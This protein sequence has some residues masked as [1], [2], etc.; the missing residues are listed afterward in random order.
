MHDA[1]EE[2][3]SGQSIGALIVA[4]VVNRVAAWPRLVLGLYLV[5]LIASVIAATGLR[6]DTDSSKMLSPTLD[7]QA[8]ALAL[9]DA[10]PDQKTAI[11]V[12]I[13]A[14]DPD[15]A[16]AVTAELASALEG[17]AGIREI[18]A[19]SIN[20]F[21]LTHGLLYL[22]TDE[23]DS[24]LSRISGSA[25]LI[26]GLRADQT[27][28]GFVST[29]DQALTL[30]EGAGETADLAPVFDEAAA[31]FDAAASGE[32]RAFGWSGIFSGTTGPVLRTITVQPEL[33]Y[34]ALNPAKPALAS[35]RET[36]AEIVMPEGVSVGVTGD[37]ALR[38]EE[39]RS[40]TAK[41]GWSLGLSLIFVIVVLWFAL[42]TFKRMLLGLGALFATLVLTTGFAAVGVGS[43]NL[44]SIAFIVLM[45]GLGIDFAIHFM[46]HLDEKA[47]TTGNALAATA[48]SI[49]PAL[50][51]TAASTSVAFFAFA[52]TDFVGM[53]QLGLIGGVGVLIAFLVSITLI[54]A[55]VSLFPT[56]AF[57]SP[58]GRI[59]SGLAAG[60]VFRLFMVAFGFGAAVLALDSR[61]DADPMGLRDPL[62]P[63]VEA[64]NW[65]AGDPD[66]SPL[67]ASAVVAA[68]DEAE[69]LR[70]LGSDLEG[71]ASATW[72]GSLLPAEQDEKLELVDLAWPSL[73]HA[74][75]GAPDTL[76]TDTVSK[77]EELPARL[78]DVPEAAALK[79][80]LSA[81]LERESAT[82]N[83]AL[84][85][86]LFTHFPLLTGR[87]EAMLEIDVVEEESLPDPLARQFSSGGFYR[88][89]FL[90]AADI[91][92][93]EERASFV[94]ALS[95][96]IPGLTG[97]PAQIEGARVAVSRAMLEAVAIALLGA[98]LLSLVTLRS[99]T[100]TLAILVPVGLAGAVCMAAGVLLDIPFNYANVIVLP[101]MIGIGVDSGIHLAIRSRQTAPV[102][103]T[104]TPMA[105]FYSAMTTIAA[106]GTLGLSDHR[107]TA[108]MGILLAIGLSA[109][110]LMTFALTPSLARLGIK[111]M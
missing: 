41:I 44:I 81:Y 58:W 79:D 50:A 35:I 45:V 22:D 9:R 19:P 91:R 26:A 110:V 27:L 14:P 85:R 65:L 96:E 28:E 38:Q 104:S 89:D 56:L 82:A 94:E 40:V 101:L 43:L 75:N 10:F 87:L 111:R 98:G 80:A 39:L 32:R 30:A 103:S 67:R 47:R 105:T 100:G 102:F 48:R 42:N 90:P 29:L 97:G 5:A 4:A 84:E 109:T 68:R 70:R 36:V 74:A 34:S 73:E 61:F 13:R 69:A 59:P 60:L 1:P 78:A 33:D 92:Q 53:A 2:G 55:I 71:I 88:V 46:A 54:P 8:R 99:I 76:T 24:Q 52:A 83:Q 106:F 66:R 77:L 20:P 3:T 7:F 64:F 63:S 37:P 51:L 23:L 31:V 15:N 86:D 25:N 72:L 49:G 57:G 62:S 16:D 95:R 21:F 6:V 18:F 17:E 108:S 107:G 93:P 12:V 11:L